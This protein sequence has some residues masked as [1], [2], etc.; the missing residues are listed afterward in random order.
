MHSLIVSNASSGG[1]KDEQVEAVGEAFEE[2]GEVTHL[3]PPSLQSFDDD[4][5]R[6]VQ[7]KDLVVIAGGD[8]TLNCALNALAGDLPEVALAIVPMGTGNDF[9]RTLGLPPDPVDAAAA[10]VGGETRAFDYG[11]AS[12]GRVERLFLNACMGGFP[13]SVNKAIDEDVKK[14]LGPLAFWVGGAK[15]AVRFPTYRLK[16]DGEV[17]DDC[18][19][20]GIGNGRTAGGGIPV[21]PEADPTDGQLECCIMQ[22]SSL[23][24]GIEMAAKV[25]SGDHVPLDN[26]R[27]LRGRRIEVEADPELEF[28]VDGDLIGLRTRCVFEVAG[29]VNMRVP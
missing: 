17:I 25:R 26:V 1:S 24:E 20:V 18:A 19:A 29:T 16:I 15:A 6:A 11:R 7:G 14:R 28:N 2:L 27:L 10:V 9:A 3:R 22:V 12:G 5:T 4:V 21:F 23:R 13:V 8:G